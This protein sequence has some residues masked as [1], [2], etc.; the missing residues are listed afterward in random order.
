MA[1]AEEAVGPRHAEAH[2]IL[3]ALADRDRLPALR[4]GAEQAVVGGDEE[5]AVLGVEAEPV[6]VA[7]GARGG[8]R[9]VHALVGTAPGRDEDDGGDGDEDQQAAKDEAAK[10]TAPLGGHG[11]LLG[12]LPLA[13]G[14]VSSL[15]LGRHL[16]RSVVGPASGLPPIPRLPGGYSEP[17]RRAPFRPFLNSD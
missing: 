1:R 9:A 16:R 6:D 10:L 15:P 13:P 17:L 14:T 8:F 7:T 4:G 11:R 12:G 2:D 5:G 3:A